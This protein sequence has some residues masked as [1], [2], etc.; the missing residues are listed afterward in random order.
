MIILNNIM[1]DANVLSN[2]Q[3]KKLEIKKFFEILRFRYDN[4][5][6]FDNVFNENILRSENI[7]ATTLVFVLKDVNENEKRE[8]SRLENALI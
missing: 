7:N 2:N 5:K 8:R 1:L 6:T 4:L 3:G